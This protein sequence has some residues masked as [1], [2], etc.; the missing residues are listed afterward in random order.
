MKFAERDAEARRVALST[1]D[2]GVDNVERARQE[3][4]K[5]LVAQTGGW[6]DIKGATL[7]S[8]DEQSLI[9]T[10]LGHRVLGLFEVVKVGQALGGRYTFH[11]I[12][13]SPGGEI[14]SEPVFSIEFDNNWRLRYGTEG[15]FTGMIQP[16]AHNPGVIRRKVLE[17]LLTIIYERLMTIPE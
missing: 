5:L 7:S 15:D 4:L 9:A 14:T 12:Q 6:A 1:I 3:L 13:R 8:D 2:Y 11:L 17:N 10:V 16:M